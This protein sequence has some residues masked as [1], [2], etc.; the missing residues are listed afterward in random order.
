[1]KIGIPGPI[2]TES[3]KYLLNGDISK[4]P[5]GYAGA[6]FLGTLIKTLIKHGHQVSAYTLDNSIP[7]N[8]LQP[9]C[10]EG[11]NFKIYY[12]ALRKHSLRPNGRYLGRIVDFYYREIKALKIAIE[13]DQP[14]IIHAHWS[15][16]FALAAIY[17]K[18]PYLVTCHD[19]PIQVLKYMSN[20]YRF[21]RLLMAL[22]VFKKAKFIT[23]VSPYLKD[24]I[25]KFT[26][27]IISVIPN[28]T[29][30]DPAINQDKIS[31]NSLDLSKPI[32][33]LVSNGWK[34][35]KNVKPAL[36]AFNILLKTKPEAS[37]HL[38]GFDQE[39]NGPAHQ[40]AK[41]NN[42]DQNMIF[43]GPTASNELLDFLHQ[44]TLLLHPALEECCPLS[45]IEAMSFGLPVVGGDKSGG[46]P[47]VLDFGKAGLLADV[48]NPE[49]I[50]KK[51]NILLEDKSI[52]LT[53]RKQGLERVSDLFSQDAVATAY[54]RI[55]QDVLAKHS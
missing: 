39:T 33:A 17:S 20:V 13:L 23:A 7:P 51:M 26:Q 6:P 54:E 52:Y 5:K 38:F 32:I 50:A 42:I 34:N 4:L 36:L 24:E 46:V 12:C 49:D 43:H 27:T 15:Y 53:I 2:S 1:M 14:D 10:A 40:W 41:A 25:Q 31:E 48:T 11:P 29:P 22:W 47:W 21:G 18:R 8:Q 30:R 3:V 37:L 16:E 19:S 35:H 44:S 45:L 9:I 55:Y 28:P